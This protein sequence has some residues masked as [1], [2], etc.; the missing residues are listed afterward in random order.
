MKVVVIN[1]RFKLFLS[2]IIGQRKSC[3]GLFSLNLIQL[4][5]IFKSMCAP[6]VLSYFFSF[7]LYY[8]IVIVL[9]MSVQ[10][11]R[12]PFASLKRFLLQNNF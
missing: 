6:L 8:I 3:L 12:P 1:R 4:R 10:F 2:I 11:F 9:I 7:F 5:I